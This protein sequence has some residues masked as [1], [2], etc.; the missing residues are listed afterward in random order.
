MKKKLKK[1]TLSRETLRHLEEKGLRQ[2]IG[3]SAP[4]NTESECYCSWT[5][6]SEVCLIDPTCS[7]NPRVC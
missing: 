4:C 3:A 6:C 1:L 5:N 7:G 2:A